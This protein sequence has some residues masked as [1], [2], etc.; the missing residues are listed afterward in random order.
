MSH[1]KLSFW[2]AVL[3][4]LNVMFGAGIFIN[5]ITLAHYAGFFGFLSYLIVAIALIPLIISTAALLRFYPDGGFYVYAAKSISPLAGFIS[6][7]AYFTGKLASAAL[8]VHVFSSLI[9]TLFPYLA[10]INLIALDIALIC[11]FAWLNMMHMKTGRTIMYTFMVFKMAPILFAILSCLYLYNFWSIPPQT[12]LWSG[13]PITFPFV[14]FAFTGF[15]VCCSLSGSIENAQKNGPRIIFLTYGIVV[16]ITI[17]YQLLFFLTAGQQLMA[18]ENYLGVFPTL[19]SLLLPHNS[20]M[21]HHL[22]ALVHTAIACA[23]LG[24]CYGILFSN[25]WNLYTLAKHNHTF[26]ASFLSRLNPHS[27][28][29]ACIAAEALL[30]IVYLIITQG[31]VVTLQQISVLGSVIA[32]AMSMI[33]LIKA[34][35]RNNF[36]QPRWLAWLALGSCSLFIAAC[37]RNFYCNGLYAFYFFCVI[38]LFGLAMFW[39]TSKNTSYS[40]GSK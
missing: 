22:T 5:T 40:A 11:L 24:G 17:V 3:V 36:L 30:C 38:A 33:G 37:I 34:N 29:V 4:N 8:L 32:Y 35:K 2:T 19:F 20:F 28:P 15:E 12:L 23:S 13:I 6:S 7:W 25:H 21:A 39:L 14:L 18:Q 27:I 9:T 16:C 1:H 31:A 26:F 10:H